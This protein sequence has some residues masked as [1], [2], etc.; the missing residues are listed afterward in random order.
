MLL[1]AISIVFLILLHCGSYCEAEKNHDCPPTSCGSITNISYPFR[2]RDD[3]ENCGDSSYELACENNRTILYLNS[4]RFFVQSISY[5]NFTIRLLDPGLEKTSCASFPINSLSYNYL[6]RL[7]TFETR[8]LFEWNIPIIFIHCE[9]PGK[10]PYYV[11]T[12]ICSK[13]ISL[14]KYSYLV[15]GNDVS[16]ADLEDSC[17]IDTMA[18][19]SETFPIVENASCS[20]IQDGLAYGFVLR[21]YLVYCKDCEGYCHIDLYNNIECTKKCLVSGPNTFRGLWPSCPLPFWSQIRPTI[22][23][24]SNSDTAFAI[25]AAFIILPRVPPHPAGRLLHHHQPA[26]V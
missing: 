12:C 8:F 26:L 18:W 20:D 17:S 10:S 11:D 16:V 2:L 15:V 7:Y 14:Q 13:N 1:F 9:A 21:W 5:N 25:L 3:P 24:D 22:H 4:S 23:L 6:S 19:I